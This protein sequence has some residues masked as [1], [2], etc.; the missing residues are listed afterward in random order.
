MTAEGQGGTDRMRAKAREEAAFQTS[1]PAGSR[2]DAIAL[3]AEF[4]Q[5]LRK[6]RHGMLSGM[7]STLAVLEAKGALATM[8]RLRSQIGVFATT[9]GP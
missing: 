8:R 2:L 1:A 5:P 4:D 3:R 9:P 7:N 6:R